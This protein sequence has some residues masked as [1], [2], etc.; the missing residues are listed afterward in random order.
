M[1]RIRYFKINGHIVWDRTKK[2]DILTGSERQD[3]TTDGMK[4]NLYL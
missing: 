3:E 4:K 1:H 2:L